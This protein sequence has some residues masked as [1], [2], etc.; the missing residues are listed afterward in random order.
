MIMQTAKKQK[1][2]H[3]RPFKHRE[4][5]T[6]HW[7]PWMWTQNPRSSLMQVNTLV[8]IHPPVHTN[9]CTL[10]YPFNLRRCAYQ[11][12]GV[13][14][15]RYT[16]QDRTT[17][18]CGTQDGT[19]NLMYAN[20]L[21]CAGSP[22]THRR[23]YWFEGLPTTSLWKCTQGQSCSLRHVYEAVRCPTSCLSKH[24]DTLSHTG[25]VYR[26][27]DVQSCEHTHTGCLLW[28]TCR[29]STCWCAYAG[30]DMHPHAGTATKTDA[31][32]WGVYKHRE[33]LRQAYT[34][35]IVSCMSTQPPA[36]VN[37]C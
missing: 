32:S 34:Q 29:R 10:G 19:F 13:A 2:T 36:Y 6:V 14:S 33:N 28:F 23:R 22:G 17:T 31:V 1:Y 8:N 25:Q 30:T 11:D 9:M 16:N 20:T 3:D 35:G 12:S 21:I 24:T 7:W 4:V 18:L 37:S 15:L 27:I 5:H 26:R